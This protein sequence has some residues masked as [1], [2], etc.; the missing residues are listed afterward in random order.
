MDL[1]QGAQTDWPDVSDTH[2]LATLEA[3]L[4]P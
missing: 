4:G 1:E 3:W 2:L